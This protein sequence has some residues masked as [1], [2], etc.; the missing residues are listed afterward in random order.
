[1][2][3]AYSEGSC[4]AVWGILFTWLGSTCSFRERSQSLFHGHSAL[5][6]LMFDDVGGEHCPLCCDDILCDPSCSMDGGVVQE[7]T[8]TRIEIFVAVNYISSS[9]TTSLY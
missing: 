4:Y 9:L 8:P 6:C 7:T 2:S 3:E 5:A 1:M